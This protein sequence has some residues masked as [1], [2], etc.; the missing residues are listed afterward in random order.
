M[1]H[2][3]I[4]NS[5]DVHTVNYMENANGE[6]RFVTKCRAGFFTI[7]EAPAW[8]NKLFCEHPEE[9]L[10]N[11]KKGALKT[12]QYKSNESGTWL[13]VFAMKGKNIVIIDEAILADITVGTVN[14]LF[15]K[16]NL[17]NQN[18]YR[19]VNAKNWNDKAY[20]MNETAEEKAA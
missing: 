9:L 17:Y 12:V 4:I 2:L 5:T 19:L 6:F 3:N 8:Q 14:S 13:T 10:R 15:F 20:V 7:S 11:W 1:T 18:Q 16:S